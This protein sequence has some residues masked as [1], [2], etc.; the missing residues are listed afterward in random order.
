MANS[1]A[2]EVLEGVGQIGLGG[3]V[4]ALDFLQRGAQIFAPRFDGAQ[5]G[6]K[7]QAADIGIAGALLFARDIV[8]QVGQLAFQ[9]GL[10]GVDR[11][12]AALHL[13]D[14]E[15]LQ[16]QQRIGPVHHALPSAPPMMAD[17]AA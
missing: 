4:F 13:V 17:S 8:V 14:A 5:E 3:G 11:G 10:H 15:A 7:G 6:R 1:S 9:I 2:L 16:A 12:H